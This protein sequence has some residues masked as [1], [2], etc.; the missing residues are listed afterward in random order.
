MI[1][2]HTHL[3]WGLGLREAAEALRAEMR[4]AGVGLS[5]V[6]NVEAGLRT[7]R[8]NVGWERLQRALREA[9][10]YS[11]SPRA[12]YI[13]SIFLEPERALREHERVLAEISRD[14]LEFARGLSGYS[15][16][17]PVISYNPDLSPQQNLER[18]RELGELSLGMKVFP[19][20]HFLDPDRPSLQPLYAEIGSMG[21]IVIVHT[22]CDPG[23]WELPAF[24]TARPSSVARAARKNRGVKFVV[25]H[26]GAYSAL[27]PGIYFKEALEALAEENVYADTSAAEPE[28]VERAVDEVGYDKILYGSDYPA[29]AGLS[30]ERAVREV[31][32]LNIEERAKRAITRENALKVLKGW[33]GWRRISASAP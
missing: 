2:F 13:A 11:F 30:M 6:I 15:D 28:F 29:V 23:I 20:L 25:A 8:E 5:V 18:L 31:L 16:L 1:D 7:F 21:G 4:R 12:G 14:S 33:A 22:G 26:L 32:G 24:C 9:L 19:T 27:N 10:E 17:V 3:P